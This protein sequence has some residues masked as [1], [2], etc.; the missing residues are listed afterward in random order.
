MPEK[1]SKKNKMIIAALAIAIAAAVIGA[2]VFVI[3][4]G[5]NKEESE[6][7]QLLNSHTSKIEGGPT[8]NMQSLGSGNFQSIPDEN[9]IAKYY[10]YYQG[11]KVGEIAEANTGKTTYNGINCH[12]I[13][14]RSTTSLNYM[15]YE[16]AFT[17][18][19][20]YYINANN[21]IPVYMKADYAYSK[22]QKIEASSTI[23]WNQ[24]TGEIKTTIPITN[25]EITMV[26]PTEYWGMIDSL[27][28]LYVGYSN[29]VYYT[30]QSEGIDTD[31]KMTISVTDQEDV[32]VPAGTFEDCYVIQFVQSEK[33]SYFG[34]TA[35]IKIWI[36]PEG[37]VPKANTNTG[38]LD[39]TQKLEG[40][41][42]TK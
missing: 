4:T 3:F 30:M 41:Y 31:M 28:D 8:V 9:C 39:L 1:K 38:G 18:D 22:P 37:V 20:T 16:I 25:K 36:S 23:S 17:M 27:D 11:E 21:N 14:G 2:A 5:E 40:Y 29:T 32:T 33:N 6:L 7:D 26:F 12:R 13:I 34:Q 15:E 10:L 19:Y 42:T 35:S 24:N